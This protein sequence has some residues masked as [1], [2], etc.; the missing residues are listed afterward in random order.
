MP[1]HARRRLEPMP[2][3]AAA[4]S[5]ASASAARPRLAATGPSSAARSPTGSTSRWPWSG[6]RARTWAAGRRS[7]RPAS[8]SGWSRRASVRS[9]GSDR[10]AATPTWTS[11]S[12][13]MRRSTREAGRTLAQGHAQLRLSGRGHDR[14]LRVSRTIADL[15]GAER[16][17]P[18]T[19]RAPSASGAEGANDGERLAPRARRGRLPG[20]LQDLAASPGRSARDRRRGLARGLRGRRG[21]D[22]RLQARRARTASRS[23]R[24]WAPA[25]RRRARGGERHGARDRRRRP[26]RRARR[27]AAQRS[28]SSAAAR[29]SSIRGAS[30]GFTS[31]SWRR[32]PWSPRCR[33]A[34][35]RAAAA[36][37]GATGSWPRSGR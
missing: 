24:S 2:V 19:S 26:P 34:P 27:R 22:R 16:S 33:P 36:F 1:L 32:A 12:C 9:G 10:A 20:A 30:A 7:T 4:R 21:D 8:A 28:P 37:R 18:S 25:R 5:P 11:P 3:R 15:A 17:R 29:T 31:A 14:V 13:A 23:P 6:R 35:A